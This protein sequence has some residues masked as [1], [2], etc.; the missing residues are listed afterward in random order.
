MVKV[1]KNGGEKKT[2][3]FKNDFLKTKKYLIL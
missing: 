1:M 3:Q 2:T